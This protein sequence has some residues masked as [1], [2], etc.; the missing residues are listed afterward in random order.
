MVAFV[1]VSVGDW[2]SSCK[3]SQAMHTVNWGK[4]E[5]VRLQATVYSVAGDRPVIRRLVA[6]T[7]RMC[8]DSRFGQLP[9][10]QLGIACSRPACGRRGSAACW[11]PACDPGAGAACG[12]LG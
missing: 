4:L 1:V 6:H 9:R 11:H 2:S 5:A 12:H 3:P 8:H 10:R 7:V